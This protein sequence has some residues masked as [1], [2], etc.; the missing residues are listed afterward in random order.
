MRVVLDT[1]VLVSAFLF[2]R[3]LEFIVEGISHGEFSPCFSY[4]TWSELERVLTYPHLAKAFQRANISAADVL[5][6]LEVDAILVPV[7]PSSLKIP[8]D[9]DDESI[10][11]CAAAAR[12]AAIV[13]GDRHLLEVAPR[14]FIPILTPKAFQ[15]FVRETTDSTGLDHNTP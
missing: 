8:T 6:R 4:T 12:A 14:F 11:A 1:N 15:V 10:L 7:T 9:P 3:H 5:A 13:T 2:G